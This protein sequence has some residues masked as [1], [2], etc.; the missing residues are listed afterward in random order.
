MFY[1]GNKNS[2]PM[3]PDKPNKL[4]P[5]ESGQHRNLITS[6]KCI[7]SARM[8]RVIH[9]KFLCFNYN[10]DSEVRPKKPGTPCQRPG[11]KRGR[12]ENGQCEKQ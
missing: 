5:T 3:S 12:C 1:I 2:T 8:C 11:G 6:D 10:G 4:Q 9:A 7:I